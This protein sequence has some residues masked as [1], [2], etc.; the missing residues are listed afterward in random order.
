MLSDIEGKAAS[1]AL[2]QRAVFD[3]SSEVRETAVSVLAR[4]PAEE[5]QKTLVDGLR[6]P[7]PAAADH[8]AEALAALKNKE[9]TPYL[10]TML[11]EPD[12]RLP[13][14]ENKTYYIRELVRMSHMSNCMVCHAPSLS[15]EDL[16]RGRVPV[17][18]ED[19]PPLYYAHRTGTF[20]RADTTFL[21]QDFSLMQPVANA[22]KWP[23][24]Q[25]FDYL[26]RA[27]PLNPAEIRSFQAL[28]KS[29]KITADYPQ[30]EAVLF[31]LRAMTGRDEGSSYEG[32]APLLKGIPKGDR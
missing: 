10:I 8:A 11:K 17:P 3:V 32:W 20:V 2:A 5:Y 22:G 19:P 12:P 25:R 16:V 6:Y 27:R 18:G 24:N 1:V 29:G 21:K 15:K 28:E 9:A 13:I 31:A 23:G 30:K 14:K 26:V 4:R 7:W